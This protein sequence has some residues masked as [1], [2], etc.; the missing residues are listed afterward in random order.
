MF[1]TPVRPVTTIGQLVARAINI[2]VHVC[3]I[4][5]M[6]IVKACIKLFCTTMVFCQYN[7]RFESLLKSL[8]ISI[9]TLA[10]VRH[11]WSMVV[12]PYFD[13]KIGGRDRC[14]LIKG[15]LFGRIC[16]IPIVKSLDALARR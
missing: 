15:K 11:F 14:E 7:V 8:G 1:R 13:E 16:R 6:N 3:F 10:F 12:F 5:T 2:N 9:F 4:K